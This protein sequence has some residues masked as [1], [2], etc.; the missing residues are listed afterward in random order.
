LRLGR[1]E[2][3]EISALFKRK[4]EEKGGEGKKREDA[5]L[6]FSFSPPE[7]SQEDL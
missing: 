4:E 5:S 6:F 7:F 3:V 2:G 1:K